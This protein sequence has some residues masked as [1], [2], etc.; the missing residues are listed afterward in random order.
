MS[1]SLP[2]HEL[3]QP[4]F[5]VLYYLPE[6]AQTHVHWVSDAIQPSHPLS[7]PSPPIFNLSQ[8]QGLF[9]WVGSSN[10]VA[11]V[12]ASASVL[13]KNTQDWSLEW[14]GWISLQ[15]KGLSRVFS[16][17]TVQK[18]PFFSTLYSPI[19]TSIHDNWKNHS[20]DLCQQLL[21]WQ[22]HILQ[23][24]L[25]FWMSRL[26]LHVPRDLAKTLHF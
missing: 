16:N 4:G 13:P 22:F 3:Q 14:T 15:P 12:S 5:P 23:D 20:F 11:K 19:L 7:S 2:P 17:T 18:H 24:L 9:Q 10:Q 8:H 6:L 25:Q 21:S 26:K 1:D